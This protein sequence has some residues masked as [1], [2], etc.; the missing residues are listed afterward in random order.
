MNSNNDGNNQ[1]TI[2]QAL[3]LASTHHVNGNLQEAE[4]LLNKILK[5]EPENV[6]AL[7]SL[8]CLAHQVQQQK[9]AIELIERAI[10]LQPDTALF[11]RNIAEMYRQAGDTENAI[12]HGKKSI[13]LEPKSAI[14]LSNLGI[15]YFDIKDYQQA[16]DYQ[17]Q[18]L[19][20]DESTVTALNNLG[21]VYRALKETDRA[22][23]YYQKTMAINPNYAESL[24]NLGAVFTEQSDPEQGMPLLEKAVQLNP[25]YAE[26]Y[27]NLGTC[28]LVLE[29][30]Q[31]ATVSFQSALKLK[32][33]FP[34][35][36]LGL[37]SIEQEANN[38]SN[39]EKLINQAITVDGNTANSYVQLAGLLNIMG[40]PE[41]AL[42][43]YEQALKI[44]PQDIPAHVG[45]GNFLTEQGKLEEADRY[46]QKALTIDATSIATHISR[47][48]LKKVDDKNKSFQFLAEKE[49][50][51]ATISKT[52]AM[53][54]NFALGK[55]ND[56]IGNYRQ[57]FQH[58]LKACQ[59]KRDKIEYSRADNTMATL[60]I[61]STFTKELINELSG[62]GFQSETPIFVLGMPRSGTTLTEQIIASHPECHGAGELADLGT[63]IGSLDTGAQKAL[64]PQSIIDLSES[65]LKS[66][67]QSY[68]AGLQARKPD[69]RCITDKMPSNYFYLGLIHLILPNAKIVHVKRNP[70]DTCISNFSKLF[71]HGQHFSYDLAELGYYYRD[72][73]NLMTHWKKVLP[74]GSFYEVNY[75]NLVEN[76]ETESKALIKYCGLEWDEKCLEFHTNTR[77]IRTASVTQVRQPIYKSSVQRWRH[78]ESFIEPLL[79]ALD[80]LAPKRS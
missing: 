69:A 29:K 70:V 43:S 23:D 63:L 18:A 54:I 25:G 33:H 47:V 26:A 27:R 10:D 35:A 65:K 66:L 12:S 48:Q 19:A 44:D 21:S 28:Y 34:E 80:D 72:Y 1:L 13:I 53:G 41:R 46:L 52:K 62:H 74:Q 45:I 5:V 38:F 36:L 31:Q 59:L 55:C 73:N 17:K 71:K 39:A 2:P 68:V 3:Q 37:A 50:S 78:Y 40:F 8:G 76:T 56:D 32:P 49:K 61:I 51:I 16:I 77:S 9:L 20:I 7:H 24:N 42:E 60:N 6:Y 22:I 11:H 14:A 15:A 75:E 64:Y 4:I 58:F 57:G 67:G 30:N 79:N